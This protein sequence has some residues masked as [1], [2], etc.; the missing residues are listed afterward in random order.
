MSLTTREPVPRPPSPNGMVT[1]CRPTATYRSERAVPRIMLDR[2]L[3]GLRVGLRHEGSWR[4]WMFIV[5][6][7]SEFLRRDGA[8]PVVLR[9]GGRVSDEGEETR[10]DIE[11]WIA[12]IDCGISGLGTCGSC[13]SN[14][15]SDAVELERASKP[16]VVAVCEEFETHG[17]NMAAYLGHKDLRHLVFPYPL[18]SL[19]TESWRRIGADFYPL[20]LQAIGVHA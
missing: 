12:S 5:D 16:A 15:V 6:Q 14:S 1:I 9:A 18:E 10:K 13:T 7:W 3:A 11:Q 17:R 4:S 20:F 8:E 19:P 2:P